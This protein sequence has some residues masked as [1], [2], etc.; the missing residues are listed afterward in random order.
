MALTVTSAL[1]YIG[2]LRV[3]F[4]ALDDPQYVVNNPWIRSFSLE[5]L[6]HI[7][8]TP[9]F[10]NYSPLHLLSYTM[11]YVLAGGPSILAFHL[12]SNIWAGVVAGFVF[13]VALAFTRNQ[14]VAMAAAI[15]FIV[16]PA[17]VEPIAWISS[18][19]DLVAAA[20]AL[21]SLL[22]Y[23][24]YRQ[25]GPAANRWYVASLLLFVL[26]LGG[27]LSVATFPAVFLAHDLFIEKRKLSRSLW[28]KVPFILAVGVFAIMV[29]S[30]QPR[31][32]HH[33]NAYVVMSAFAESAW[34][35]TGFGRYVMYRV[36]PNQS[37]GI[38]LQIVAA[39]L[40]MI[41]FAAPLLLRRR[42]PLAVVLI[43]WI[44]F[45]LLPSQ[46]LA[47]EFPVADRYLFFPSVAAVILIAWALMTAA[48]R[49]GRNGLAAAI[50]AL[51]VITLLWGRTTLHYLAE[52]R[53][54]RSVWYGATQKS[55][56]PEAYANLGAYYQD[57]AGRFGATQPGKSLSPETAERLGRALWAG[58]SRLSALLSELSTGQQD[59]PAE[60]QFRSYLRS[61]AWDAYEQ[62]IRT[63]GIRALPHIYFRR[64][65]ILFND[66][67]LKGA[68]RELLAAADE[69]TKTP[70][71][72]WRA[73]YLVRSHNALGIVAWRLENYQEALRWL[74]MAEDE[75]NRF[76]GNWV[77]DISANRKKLEAIVGSTTP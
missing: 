6:K 69:A 2:I 1:L 30:A 7:F 34:L 67:D 76:G 3:D 72:E 46:A 65:G 50:V 39:V 59:G 52:W 45:G 77:T 13:L 12:S 32:G 8:T 54:P 73:E 71:P 9:Y 47:F 62:R 43:Y 35:L 27:K 55:S 23:L 11:D 14:I 33:P 19:K 20:F 31:T 58:D 70:Q 36:P 4:L 60:G 21:L 57:I 74:R 68:R 15:L 22:T 41:L 16:H 40:L 29:A 5:N 17:H 18:R 44:L 24:R 64:S 25:H 75:Q 66:G 56:D 10:V 63:K 48:P 49:F 26:A 38:M 28:D 53:D 61:L 42:S 37:A 51:A